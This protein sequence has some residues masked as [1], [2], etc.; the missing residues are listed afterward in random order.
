VPPLS[1]P[2]GSQGLVSAEGGIDLHGRY[3]DEVTRFAE[4]I[5]DLPAHFQFTFPRCTE[6]YA[7]SVL[8]SGYRRVN[9]EL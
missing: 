1:R 9:Y 2:F 7:L 4:F 3:F 8:C 5:S 6:E